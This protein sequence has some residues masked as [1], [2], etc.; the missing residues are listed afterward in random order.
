MLPVVAAQSLLDAARDL[1]RRSG[2]VASISAQN[3]AGLPPAEFDAVKR[4]FERT[5]GAPAELR[6][7]VSENLSGYVL[8]AEVMR[9]EDRRIFISTAPRA[10]ASGQVPVGL[11]RTLLFEQDAP[12]LDFALAPGGRLLILSPASVTLYERRDGNWTAV[13]STPLPTAPMRDPRGRLDVTADTFRAV[14]PSLS[15]RGVMDANLPVDCGPGNTA[16]PAGRVTGELVTACGRFLLNTLP[17][18]PP[19]AIQTTNA[20]LDFAGSVTR[21][22]SAGA[23][24]RDANGRYAAY[25]LA[26]TCA[27]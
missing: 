1:A 20:S 25:A 6:L 10:A 27:R 12:I 18:A 3:P 23:V 8:V 16:F 21:I 9:A 19:D 26:I 7:T 11:T 17:D 13:K 22:N 15:C 5:P 14:F 4:A 24:V 2:P